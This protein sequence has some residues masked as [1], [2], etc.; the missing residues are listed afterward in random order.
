MLQTFDTDYQ[1]PDSASTA[2]AM[3]CGPSNY[4]K[5][6][7]H[8]MGYDSHISEFDPQSGSNDTNKVT[9]FFYD[10]GSGSGQRH[11]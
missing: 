5:T 3:F 8:T 9:S 11:R 1:T 4:V 6:K 2:S 7:Y 10:L